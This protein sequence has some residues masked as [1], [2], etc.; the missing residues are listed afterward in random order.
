VCEPGVSVVVVGDR[1]DVGLYRDLIR[2]GVSDYIVKPLTRSLVQSAIDTVL[3]ASIPGSTPLS[4]KA[5]RV[6]TVVGARGGVGTT[7]IAANLAWYLANTENRRVCLVDLDVIYGDCALTL[8]IKLNSTGGLREALESPTR[9]DELLVERAMVRSGDRLF[10]LGS[11]ERL[12]TSFRL[13]PESLEPLLEVLRKQFHYIVVDVPRG[14]GA[15]LHRALELSNTRIV[16]LDQTARSIRDLLRL[17]SI[18]DAPQIGQRNLIVLN[19]LGEGGKAD[20]N[21]ATLAETIGMPVDATVAFHPKSVV[22]AANAGKP[23]VGEK[24]PI[25]AAIATIAAELSGRHTARRRSF[26]SKFK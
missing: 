26:W 6:V 25:A 1:N 4:Q 17:R 12:E 7:T 21:L 9:I 8:D 13:E 16:V 24:G 14:D 19:R 23:I 11:E 3:G 5:G 22:A 10:L 18:I 2:A 15:L 20:I